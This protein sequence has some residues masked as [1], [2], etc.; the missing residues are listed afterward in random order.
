M[1]DSETEP[2]F[3]DSKSHPLSAVLGSILQENTLG[4]KQYHKEAVRRKA[5][6]MVKTSKSKA[7][8]LQVWVVKR[9]RAV[10]RTF[11]IKN[12]FKCVGPGKEGPGMKKDGARSQKG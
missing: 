7:R 5:V 12:H 11:Q 2:R 1:A 6:V 10:I 4:P 8:S 3:S 9:S